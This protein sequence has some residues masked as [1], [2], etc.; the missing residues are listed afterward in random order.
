MK[1]IEHI[2]WERLVNQGRV[3]RRPGSAELVQTYNIR[4]CVEGIRF[5]ARSGRALCDCAQ[6]ADE[7]PAIFA[8]SDK[9]RL[10]IENEKVFRSCA[11]GSGCGLEDLLEAYLE[12]PSEHLVHC[13]E[14]RR[15]PTCAGKEFPSA[16][17]ELL[18]SSVGQLLDTRLHPLLVLR[19]RT[20]HVLGVRHHLGWDRRR[21]DVGLIGPLACGHLL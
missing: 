1:D 9:V 20:R 2:L 17:P 10:I 5:E 3:P 8:P 4:R 21:K 11:F 18:R 14:R 19:L 7:S 13:H 6:R 12:E 15:Y 16:D